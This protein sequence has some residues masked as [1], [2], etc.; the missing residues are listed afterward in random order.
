MQ[1]V[2]PTTEHKQAALDFRQ[3]FFNHGEDGIDGGAGLCKAPSYA[4]WLE[5]VED[6]PTRV[7]EKWVPSSTYFAVDSGKI[8]GIVDIRHRLND[9]LINVGGHIGYSVRP[10]ERRKGYATE[11]L[12]LALEKCRE[13]GIKSVLVTCNSDNIGSEKAILKNGGVRENTF[14]EEDGTVVLRH[15]IEVY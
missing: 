10:A 14:L 15:W 11:I 6:A 8:V 13:M 12:R 9:H 1:L 3:E 7:H 2:F 5:V 4:F